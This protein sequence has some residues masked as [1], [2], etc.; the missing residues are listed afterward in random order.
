M[1]AQMSEEYILSNIVRRKCWEDNICVGVSEEYIA[2]WHLVKW[3][4]QWKYIFYVDLGLMDSAC[5]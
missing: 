3:E 5:V 4:E 2:I 1:V